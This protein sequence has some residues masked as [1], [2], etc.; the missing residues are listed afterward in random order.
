MRV[1]LRQEG[2]R[3]GTGTGQFGGVPGSFFLRG[4]SLNAPLETG[5]RAWIVAAEKSLIWGIGTL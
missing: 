5:W 3:L 4:G 1:I 2:S